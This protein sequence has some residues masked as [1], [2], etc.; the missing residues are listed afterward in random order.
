MSKIIK[1]KQPNI[2]KVLEKRG[3]LKIKNNFKDPPNFNKEEI[4]IIETLSF[5]LDNVDKYIEKID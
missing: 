2:R 3:S 4:G 5:Y 1:Q